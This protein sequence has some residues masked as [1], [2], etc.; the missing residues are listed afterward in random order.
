MPYTDA[1]RRQVA[2]FFQ[3]EWDRFSA[4]FYATEKNV[5]PY[6]LVYFARKYAEENGHP[7]ELTALLSEGYI[8][9]KI[10]TKVLNSMQVMIKKF[11][12]ERVPRKPPPPTELL[13]IPMDPKFEA[14]A[15]DGLHLTRSDARQA[16]SLPASKTSKPNSSPFGSPLYALS[17][18]CPVYHQTLHSKGGAGVK[19]KR[20]GLL[21]ITFFYLLE[22]DQYTLIARGHHT[23]NDTYKVDE[24]LNTVQPLRGQELRFDGLP[25]HISPPEFEEERKPKSSTSTS[26]RKP[27]RPPT[28]D[29]PPPKS[30]RPSKKPPPKKKK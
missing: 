30:P 26:S 22:G 3:Q 1:E 6:A 8:D 28:P 5:D 29:S 15:A 23:S 25:V 21:K 11:T 14:Q 9:D 19:D 2:E 24:Q 7:P 17:F 16:L 12:A 20:D 18:P 27:G 10:W 13:G 4:Y